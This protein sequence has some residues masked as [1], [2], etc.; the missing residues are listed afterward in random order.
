MNIK[1]IDSN[2]KLFKE[3]LIEIP[4]SEIDNSI[5]E[6]IIKLI[7][8]VTLPGFR[9]GKAPINIVKKKYENSILNEVVEKIV[10]EKTKKLLEEKKLIAFR[11]PKVEIKKYTKNE[12]IELG[13]KIDLQPEIKIFPFD[14]IESIKYN[15]NIDKK[16]FEK[17]YISFLNSQKKYIKINKNRSI[18]NTDKVFIDITTADNSAPDYL[19]SQ[20]NISIITDS[21]YQILPEISNK[22]IKKNCKVGDKIKLIFDLKIL[23]KEKKEKKIEFEIAILSIEEKVDFKVD[24][25]FLKHNNLKSED[26]L[27]DNLNKN[28]IDQYKNY[29]NEIEKKQ[30]MDKLESN[31]KFDIPEGI[32]EEEFKMIWHRVEHAKKEEKLDEDDKKLSVEKLKKRYEKIA[33]RRV[34]L[35][36][37]MQ[38]ISRDENII[39]TEKELTEGMMNYASQYPGQ[40]KKIF[41]YFK[42]NPSNIESISGP[43]LEKKIVD[44]ILSKTKKENKKISINEFNKLQEETFNFSKGQ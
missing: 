44:F 31:N 10:Q 14:K 22:L 24:K 13:I 27:K 32:F 42:E 15:L 8:T 18:K 12:P 36:V 20:K 35:A 16:T 23:L 29:I 1:E 2:K 9:K 41:D 34:K 4:Y 30:L 28:L 33:L 11:Q 26:E 37:I 7:P 43:I 19:K 40:E 25:D 38:K 3:Y 6:R 21:D 39:V 5:D 17:N